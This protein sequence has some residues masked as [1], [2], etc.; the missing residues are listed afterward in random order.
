M[1]E[2]FIAFAVGAGLGVSFAAWYFETRTAAAE[3]ACQGAEKNVSRLRTQLGDKENHIK[4][5]C[6]ELHR[7]KASGTAENRKQSMGE[8]IQR[9]W[10]DR[11]TSA[12]LPPLDWGI[13][14]TVRQG[15][16]PQVDQCET[17]GQ[18]IEQATNCQPDTQP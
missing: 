1:L 10:N 6:E 11:D 18:N 7:L 9:R 13:V 17:S 5:L 12:T 16:G 14:P 3:K 4:G 15:V 2:L 8:Q